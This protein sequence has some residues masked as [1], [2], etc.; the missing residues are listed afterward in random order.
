MGDY[1]HD[2]EFGVFIE[3]AAQSAD[4]VVALSALAEEAGYDLV[5]FN[6]HLYS[7]RSLDVWTLMSFVA[8]RTDR[9]RLA[10]NVL[11]LPLRPPAV[12]ARAVTSL[13][14][15][16][17]GRAELGI[18]AG[19]AWEG[20][21]AMGGRRLDP[22]DSI[23]AL[24]EGIHVIRELLDADAQAGV[25][26]EG[27]HYRL[28]G[29]LRGPA[30]VHDI[31]MWVG[32]FKPRML[33]LVGRLADGWWPTVP[34][35]KPGDLAAGNA[36]IDAA[37]ARAGREPHA[38]RRLLN[39]GQG[40]APARDTA[41]ELARLAL[42]DGIG[43]FIVSVNDPRA[44]ADF[45]AEVAPRVREA[46]EKARLRGPGA[47]PAAAG[48]AAVGTSAPAEAAT[49]GETA[50][51][52]LGVTPTPDEAIRHSYRAPWDDSARPRR[53]RTGPEV[54]YTDQGRRVAKQLIA[55]H[56]LLRGELTE[57][58][59]I[60]RQVRDGAMP[61]GDARAAL[62]DMALRQNDWTLGAFCARYCSVVAQHHAAEDAS[63]FPH[64]ARNEPQL[65]P[66]IDRLTEEHLVIHDAIQEVDQALVQHMTR[67]DNHDAIQ[68]AIDYL[69]DALLS[70]L[71]Y[72]E[73]E[74]VEPLARLGFYPDQVPL[75]S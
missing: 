62:N 44:I 46:V 59:D 33:R 4:Q 69:T 54:I 22:G 56:D 58:R 75:R 43:T 30:P 74:L 60:L 72:E 31:S 57:L 14:I 48:A 13:D 24:E 27:K 9:V 67:P 53:D 1:G 12:L 61:A 34:A 8:A 68:G 65:K 73:Q 25:R 38:I 7:P 26:F 52:R 70:H 40:Y 32:A 15:L 35:L 66:V 3:P 6:D 21:E 18:G 19:I 39:L 37:A 20:I 10:P 28:A 41:A 71:A 50:D 17:H 47:P 63:L 16:S 49:P 45:A 5:T 55:V 42:E 36:V 64:L 11:S 29:A 51:E 23:K 2:L